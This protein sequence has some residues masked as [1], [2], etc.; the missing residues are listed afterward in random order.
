M[1]K[2]LPTRQRVRKALI[3]LAFLTFPITI[4]YLSPYLI[5]ESAAAGIVNGSLIM[6]GS[7]FVSSLFVGRLWCGWACPGAGMQ[8]IVEPVNNRR[9]NGRKIDW[10]K[11]LIWIPWIAIIV[12]TAAQAGGYSAADFLYGTE[13]GISVAGSSERPIAFAYVVYY[14]VIVLFVGLAVVVGKRAG[15]HSICWM[16]PFMMIGRWIRNRV[17][18]PAL[19]RKANA[20]ACTGCKRCVHACPMGL[21]VSAMVTAEAMENAE[22]V[23]CG[24]CVDT[25][26]AR[27]VR[28][29]FSAGRG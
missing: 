13:G 19:R 29:S 22:C 3:I 17:G 20:H 1:T 23:L 14:V 11:W 21:D 27:A 25:C 10:I 15:C 26:A 18:W 5:V 6:F 7:M 24:S 8:E 16:A 4:F 12:L 2:Q 9:V 28:F